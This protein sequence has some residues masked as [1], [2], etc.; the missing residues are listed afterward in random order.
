MKAGLVIG[1]LVLIMYGCTCK[2]AQAE[3]AARIPVYD[4]TTECT[5]Q[6][7]GT[8]AVVGAGAGYVAGRLLFGRKGGLI[9]AA[10]GGV[11]GSQVQKQKVCQPIQKLIGYKIIKN[12]NGKVIEVFEPVQ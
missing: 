1:S 8:G 10:V 3:E 5:E 11:G 2:T 9:G 12:E 6:M 7:N 4:Q